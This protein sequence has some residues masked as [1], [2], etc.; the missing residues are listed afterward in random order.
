MAEARTP[1]WRR[2]AGTGRGCGQ[3]GGLAASSLGRGRGT[4]QPTPHTP[5]PPPLL[6]A[7]QG[8]DVRTFLTVKVLDADGLGDNCV[9]VDTGF[10]H[11]NAIFKPGVPPSA[12]RVNE[13][14]PPYC[15]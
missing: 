2:R 15:A 6:P 14:R 1:G 5:H 13:I 7:P 11:G 12:D 8:V 9:T 4:R 3:A 10:E